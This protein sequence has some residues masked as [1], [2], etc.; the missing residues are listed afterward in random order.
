MTAAAWCSCWSDAE[1]RDG[2]L[3]GPLLGGLGG[4]TTEQRRQPCEPGT[5]EVYS[6]SEGR[7]ATNSHGSRSDL[8]GPAV[9]D[10]SRRARSRGC[11]YS[12]GESLD[13]ATTPSSNGLG[14]SA[15]GRCRRRAIRQD[16]LLLVE[17]LRLPL[18]SW[19]GACAQQ[20]WRRRT[21]GPALAP[22]GRR[23]PVEVVSE[24]SAGVRG[25]G[26]A[27]RC[28][29]RD[30]LSVAAEGGWC[31]ELRRC[32]MSSCASMTPEESPCRVR[33]P[34]WSLSPR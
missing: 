22:A 15:A 29:R 5:V 16:G 23:E 13:G 33:V 7:H 10:P 17:A 12:I 27:R 4:V 8:E 24:P 25:H 1:R 34:P 21:K 6:L 28:A 32:P 26:G 18:V 14:Y 19:R 11:S 20:R 3:R 2:R 31:D 30:P 9:I